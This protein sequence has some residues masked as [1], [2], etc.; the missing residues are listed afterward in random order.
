MKE[1]SETEKLENFKNLLGHSKDNQRSTPFPDRSQQ[2]S[3]GADSRTGH[4]GGRSCVN[5]NVYVT[6][7]YDLRDLNSE[8]VRV[9]SINHT[10][11]M[12]Y[13]RIFHTDF[14]RGEL[15]IRMLA[16]DEIQ[17][18]VFRFHHHS[19]PCSGCMN[20]P[21]SFIPKGLLYMQ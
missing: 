6:L 4:V 18:L 9:V 7:F 20:N 15:E 16:K 19:T 17:M 3:E 14:L 11:Q 10:G 21:A 8:E 1:G 12:D 5:D 2:S 13:Q